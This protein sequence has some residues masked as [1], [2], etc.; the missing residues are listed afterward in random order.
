M[1][2]LSLQYLY[3]LTERII[4]ISPVGKLGAYASARLDAKLDQTLNHRLLVV[5]QKHDG[6]MVIGACTC[7]GT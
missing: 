4:V 6:Q 3:R 1:V 7:Y 5:V 2:S